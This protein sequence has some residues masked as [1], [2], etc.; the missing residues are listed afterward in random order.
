MLVWGVIKPQKGKINANISRSVKNRQLMSVRKDKGKIAITNYKTLEIFQNSN[1]PKIS[2]VECSLETGRTHQIRVHMNFI[3][4]PVLGDKSYGK[5]KKKFKNI[6]LGIE[7][8]INNF[9]RQSLHAKSLG[10]IHPS[11]GKKISFEAKRPK[12]LETL[13]KSLRITSV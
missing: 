9:K 2:L 10:F 12:D 11:T 5:S 13:I 1:L 8:K 6:D 4:N 7:K 3:G